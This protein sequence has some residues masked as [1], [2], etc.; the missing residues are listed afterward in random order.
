[1]LTFKDHPPIIDNGNWT[2]KIWNDEI[3]DYEP[4]TFEF[5]EGLYELI[6]DEIERVRSE[7][8]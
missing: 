6:K 5:I 4:H 3:G 1:M 8:I 2:I 7:K